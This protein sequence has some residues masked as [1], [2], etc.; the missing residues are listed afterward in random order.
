MNEKTGKRVAQQRVDRIHAFR[1]QLEELS[2]E[3]V[4]ELSDDQRAR[5]DSHLGQTLTELAERFD[6]DINESQ[7][8]ISLGMRVLSTLGGLAFCA[9]LLLF[10]YRF[11]GYFSTPVQVVLLAVTPILGLAALKI[12]ARRDKTSYYTALVGLVVLAS[13]I[14]NLTVL[15]YLFNTT[16]SQVSFLAWGLFALILAYAYNLRL[17]LAAG[18]ILLLFCCAATL[19][20]WGGGYWL[21][22][23]ERPESFL[24]AGIL[25]VAFPFL[26]IDKKA[27]D[28]RGVFYL[29]GL[30]AIFLPLWILV[31]HGELSWMPLSVKVSQWVYR[32]AG[33]VIAGLTIWFGLRRV[34]PWVMNLGSAF[35][36]AYL[37]DQL[38]SWWW[39]WMPKYLF[40]LIIGSIALM[41]LVVFQ[42][43]R[44]RT[45]EDQP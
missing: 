20:T 14:L 24:V 21:D 13:F 36:A 1:Q 35:F 26:I 2:R 27:V 45:R 44:T 37:F 17:P 9:A 18:L 34:I 12:V 30:L 11:W 4:L 33:F 39:D 8:R 7:K 22:C 42:R 25:I 32:M 40:F 43:L 28:F 5:L 19:A 10:F 38:I 29:V 6:V 16:P 15:G 23:F 3:Q 41:L 31:H